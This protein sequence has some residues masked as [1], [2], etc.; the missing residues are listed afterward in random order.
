MHGY[1]YHAPG[2]AVITPFCFLHAITQLHFSYPTRVNTIIS[3][4]FPTRQK[5]N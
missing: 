1:Q 2:L 5:V 4:C 3:L